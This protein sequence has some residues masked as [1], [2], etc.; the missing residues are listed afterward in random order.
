MKQLPVRCPS[1]LNQLDVIELKCQSCETK[2]SGH[3]ALPLFL[4]L[5]IEEQ[6]FVM[7]FFLNSGSLKEIAK[8]MKVSYP[9]MRNKIDNLIEKIKNTNDE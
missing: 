8:E 5:T 7:Q 3:Y 2:V 6:D 4:Q 1:C 9:T